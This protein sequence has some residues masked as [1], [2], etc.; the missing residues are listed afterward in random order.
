MGLIQHFQSEHA[1]TQVVGIGFDSEDACKQF[2]AE[3][4]RAKLRESDGAALLEEQLVELGDTGFDISSLRMQVV[5]P[6]AQKDWEVGEAFAEAA[7]E[8]HHEA[9]FPW[10]TAL[11]K[12]TPR[13]S[14]PG[15][16]LV[17]FHGNPQPRFL[18][19]E[20]KS[21]SEAACPPQVIVSGDDCLANQVR[22]LLTS[23]AHRQKLIEWL[24][25]R[26]RG[27]GWESPFEEALKRY[28]ASCSLDI[29]RSNAG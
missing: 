28:Y 16:D 1:L 9:K 8:D 15:P 24:L 2:F 17:G 29:S 4:V 22:R 3:R 6:P 18:F 14:L 27:T 10:Q 21:S 19:G 13:A 5:A 25:V 11:D 20:G 26:C 12:R 7:L 23:S